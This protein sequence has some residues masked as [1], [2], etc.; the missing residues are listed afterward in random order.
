MASL[1]DQLLNLGAVDKKKAKKSQHQKRQAVNKDR[2][3]VK[4]G[5]AVQSDDMQNQLEQTA[6]EKQ[7]RDLELNKQR[8]AALAKKALTAEVKQIV[9]LHQL[10]IAKEAD[11]A[12]NFTH[13]NKVKKIYITTDLQ[14]QLTLGQIAIVAVEQTYKLLPSKIAERIESR[15]PEIVIRIEADEQSNEVDPYEDYQIPDDLMW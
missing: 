13:S 5:K 1:Q 15:L 7:Q 4:S 8:D 6:K 3:A 12:Y 9:Q 2:K 11:I 14:K 10:N